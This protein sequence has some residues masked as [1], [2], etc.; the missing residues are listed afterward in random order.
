MDN[1]SAI[2][3]WPTGAPATASALDAAVLQ[4]LLGQDTPPLFGRATSPL[5]AATGSDTPAT[6]GLASAP[7]A[8][9]AAT[10]S[11]SAAAQA[12]APVIVSGH[13]SISAGASPGSLLRAPDLLATGERGP[14][15]SQPSVP[16]L[17]PPH[18]PAGSLARPPLLDR[19]S[20]SDA[21]LDRAYAGA[22]LEDDLADVL[23]RAALE[24]GVDL[25]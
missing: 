18:G 10:V 3:A 20:A 6:P 24:A 1:S 11:A 25:S 12:S 23:E 13:Q 17:L 5:R 9:T 22:E 2:S 15:R 8:M 21:D 16:A 4:P 14:A 7:G 19:A